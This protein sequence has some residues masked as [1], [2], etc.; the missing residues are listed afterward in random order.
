[1]SCARP[2]QPPKSSSRAGLVDTCDHGQRSPALC[3]KSR[4]SMAFC[5][6]PDL[7]GTGL[8]HLSH[9]CMHVCMYVCVY[10]QTAFES[11]LQNVLFDPTYLLR[12]HTKA[13]LCTRK[14]RPRKVDILRMNDL[15]Y[16]IYLFIFSCKFCS[17][18][19]HSTP[20]RS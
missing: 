10:R 18:N 2:C 7:Y 4:M 13:D 5:L 1:M 8:D 16:S 6:Y 9:V 11:L 20:P 17:K 14:R 3:T 15:P 19:E 12:A